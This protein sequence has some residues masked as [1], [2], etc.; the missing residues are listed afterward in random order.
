MKKSEL[1][2]LLRGIIRKVVKEVKVKEQ[3]TTGAVSPV[4]GPNAFKKKPMEGLEPLGGMEENIGKFEI[5]YLK[6]GHP[7]FVPL[8]AADLETAKKAANQWR[9]K[10]RINHVIVR[11][12][13]SVDKLDEMTTT[14]GG[15]GSSAGT[16]GYNIPGAFSRRGGSKKGIAGSA[17]LGYTLTATGKKDM[18]LKAD[19]LYEGKKK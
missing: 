8:E 18:D 6:D 2:E 16:P 3:T 1:T 9:V 14:S 4:T 12:K 10:N 15:G 13:K 11:P 7:V 5:V 17:A 19:K